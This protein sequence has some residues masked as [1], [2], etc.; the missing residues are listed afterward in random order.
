M[1]KSNLEKSSI[2]S[3]VQKNRLLRQDDTITLSSALK[4]CPF[5]NH[6]GQETK[7]FVTSL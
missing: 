5:Y 7:Q 2:N 4:H 3:A 1:V 6:L